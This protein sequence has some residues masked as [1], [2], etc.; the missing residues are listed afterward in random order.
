M[1]DCLFLVRWKSSTSK[2]A[3]ADRA[4]RTGK[5][6]VDLQTTLAMLTTT[7]SSKYLKDHEDPF[8]RQPFEDPALKGIETLNG[9]ARDYFTHHKRLS[10]LA[11]N[12][13]FQDVVRW[14][15]KRV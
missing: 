7:T 8:G 14:V 4:F 9:G 5:R 13:R 1:I 6:I 11:Q 12:Y 2:D 15:P 3:A 10:E